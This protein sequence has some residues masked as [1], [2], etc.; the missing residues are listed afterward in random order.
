LR[1]KVSLFSLLSWWKEV[2]LMFL[3]PWWEEV[4]RRGS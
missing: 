2:S 1:E 3:L 4:R